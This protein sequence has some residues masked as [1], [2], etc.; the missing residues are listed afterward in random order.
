M[1]HAISIDAAS[2]K[3][4]A[5]VV[6]LVFRDLPAAAR[7][8]QCERLLG[9]ESDRPSFG[10]AFEARRGGRLVGAVLCEIQVG[11][12]AVVWPPALVPGEP[13][14][15][16]KSLLER[17]STYLV[18]QGVCVAYALLEFHAEAEGAM[19][20]AGGFERMADLNYLA[21]M[22]A[23]FPRSPPPTAL[24]F[25][26]YREADR[27]RFARVVEST[28]EGTLDCPLLN[29]A[30]EV[31]DVLAGYRATGTF[32][33]SRWL[34]VTHREE[35]VGC[36]LLADHPQQENWELVYMG[37]VPAARGNGWGGHLVRHAQW[38]T[39]QAGRPR[40]VLAVDAMNAP[41]IR[42]YW[43]AGF[44]CWERRRAFVKRFAP[45]RP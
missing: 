38:L 14:A 5:E 27:D 10:G 37:V 40:L 32:D 34:R 2:S 13:A 20:E 21:C 33:P 17:A 31:D 6:A 7:A 23:G 28:Y 4:F 16:A 45:P 9:V 30:R 26:R 1:D 18:D 25:H 36:L 29:G 42:M 15:T 12:A 43:L 11:R 39:R 35:D 44:Q 19:L 41:A 24:E 22:E 8:E 3:T